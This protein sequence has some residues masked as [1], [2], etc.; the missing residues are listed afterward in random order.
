MNS[1]NHSTPAWNKPTLEKLGTL[2]DV[3]GP[4]GSGTEGGP[5]AK[6][7]IFRFEYER[8]VIAAVC[9]VASP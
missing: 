6:V 2:K 4:R 9:R 8:Q 5:N 1:A 3:A 7:L